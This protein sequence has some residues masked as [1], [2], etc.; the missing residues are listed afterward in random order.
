MKEIMA[1]ESSTAAQGVPS[2]EYNPAATLEHPLLFELSRPLDD[3][4]DMLLRDFAGKI[5]TMKA[6]YEQH[7]VDTPYISSNYKEILAKLEDEGKIQ[8][9]PPADR[10]PKRKGKV[11]FADRVKVTFPPGSE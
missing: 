2:F 5:R 7:N 10:R 3:L 9:N 11:T 1:G 6:I 8:V 4:A